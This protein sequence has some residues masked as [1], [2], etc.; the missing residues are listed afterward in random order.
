MQKRKSSRSD[1]IRTIL[2]PG[3]L[4]TDQNIEQIL[5]VNSN[6][7]NVELVKQLVKNLK[8]RNVTDSKDRNKALCDVQNVCN[9]IVHLQNK[10]AAS[11]SKCHST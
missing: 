2:R 8:L 9:I 4:L 5:A 3:R 7:M 10:M 11:E 6:K 1:S